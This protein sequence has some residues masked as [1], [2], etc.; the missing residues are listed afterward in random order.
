MVFRI[1]HIRSRQVGL[2]SPVVDCLSDASSTGPK[3]DSI[4]FEG[5]RQLWIRQVKDIE[6]FANWVLQR[7]TH[8]LCKL[9]FIT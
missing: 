7:L 3:V 1:S 8:D 4:F 5:V 2:F 6:G 9:F